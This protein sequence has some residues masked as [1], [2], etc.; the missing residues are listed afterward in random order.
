MIYAPPA[1]LRTLCGGLLLATLGGCMMARV[2]ELP[3]PNYSLAG[4]WELN[5][6]LSSDPDK[7][8]AAVQPKPKS[9]PGSGKGPGQGPAPEVI[10]DPTTDLPPIDTTAGHEG[11]AIY[12]SYGANDRNAYRPP[13]DFQNNA[14]L[15]G[16]WLKIR[17]TETE[18]S[19]ANAA[20]NRSF[21]P[22]ERS[23]V[24]VPSGVADQVAGWSGRD[25]LIQVRPQI[26][27]EV[28]ET[29]T[30]SADG[31]QL[32]VKIDVASEGRNRAMKVT[33]VYDRSSKDPAELRPTLQQT[34]PPADE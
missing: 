25:F 3:P 11:Q 33:R 26:G 7:V 8:L 27:P 6:A 32:L 28:Q 14:L 18:V 31:K 16:Q 4:V 9:G 20:T 21:T 5:P 22:G 10:N 30:L 12:R 1:L 34:L 23:V 2:H 24:S 15:G 29:Y 13:L 19:I 17:Q